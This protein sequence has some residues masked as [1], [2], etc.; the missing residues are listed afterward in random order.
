MT[1]GRSNLICGLA[2]TAL[3]AW[4]VLAFGSVYPWAYWPLIVAA[5]TV[6]TIGWRTT[7]PGH[8]AAGPSRGLIVSLAAAAAAEIVQVLPFSVGTL[9]W[10][11]PY[12]DSF[13]G[14][15]SAL[16]VRSTLSLEP[17][18]TA[19]S[20][21]W[22][23]SL[24]ALFSGCVSWF[25]SVG[26]SSVARGVMGVGVAL[27]LVG[28]VQEPIYSGA[29][30]GFWEPRFGSYPFGPFVNENHFAGWMM[31]GLPLAAGCFSAG[32]ADAMRGVRADWRSRVLWLS[33]SEANRLA[34]MALSPILM[35]L[36]L[37]LTFSRSGITCFSIAVLLSGWFVIRRKSSSA[38]RVVSLGHLTLMTLVVAGCAGLNA[39]TRSFSESS[40]DD[41]GGRIEIWQDSLRVISDF[42]L[43]GTGMNTYGTAALVYSANAA[44][45]LHHAHS[46][47]PQGSWTVV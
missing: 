12:G 27:A 26:A 15:Q 9:S 39:L 8:Q 10:L 4:G 34:V 25:G 11:S 41:F 5:G 40:W 19:L 37:V 14:A 16:G 47:L 2:V 33:S 22:L 36:A 42:A 31:M 3:L 43:T 30:Y 35:G 18:S 17:S 23:I 28:I 32:V 21:V 29:I 38:Q 46:V 45:R 1:L 44:G 7:V 24:A 20:I 6:A 13:F